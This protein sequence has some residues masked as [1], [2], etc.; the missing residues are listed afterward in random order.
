MRDKSTMTI[1]TG[2]SSRTLQNVSYIF[3]ITRLPYLLHE[4]DHLGRSSLGDLR[5]LVN[6]TITD[7]S[8]DI[9]EV[10]VHKW[11]LSSVYFVEDDADTV[12]WFGARGERVS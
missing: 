1:A 6:T 5:A 7:L 11:I 9:T 3:R 4:I 12:I 8:K 10:F 2:F